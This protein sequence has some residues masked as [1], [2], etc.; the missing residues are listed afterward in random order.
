MPL[1]GKSYHRVRLTISKNKKQIFNATIYDKN[2]ST[3][4]YV[5][6]KFTADIPLNDEL[7]NFKTSDH[8]KAEIIDMR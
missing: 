6:K 8:P 3:Y 7:F 1:K 5:V 2:G 4:S